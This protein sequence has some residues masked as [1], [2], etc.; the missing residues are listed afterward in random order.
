M[1]TYHCVLNDLIDSFPSFLDLRG[2]LLFEANFHSGDKSITN[3]WIVLNLDSF[4]YM[5]PPKIFQFGH[6]IFEVI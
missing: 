5:N 6:E 4:I 1:I 3:H 2:P